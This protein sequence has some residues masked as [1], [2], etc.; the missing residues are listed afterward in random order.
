MKEIEMLK[1]KYE[2]TLDSITDFLE[3]IEGKDVP[4]YMFLA[5][6]QAQ[7]ESTLIDLKE[8]I[9]NGNNMSKV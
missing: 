7:I 5:G 1:D 3:R 2:K 6:K 4:K 8:L 9:T